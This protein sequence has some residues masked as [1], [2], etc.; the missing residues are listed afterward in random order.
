MS[1]GVKK[2]PEYI[3][4][5]SW[6][7]QSIYILKKLLLRLEYI[8]KDSWQAAYVEHIEIKEL[9]VAMLYSPICGP[10]HNILF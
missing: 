10:I 9:H 8:L 3:L 6:C 1:D 7:A 5:D 4:K 2:Y